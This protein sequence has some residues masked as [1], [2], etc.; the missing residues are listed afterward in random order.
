MRTLQITGDSAYG[1][2]TYLL[3]KWCRYLVEKGCSV[4]VVSTDATTISALRQIAGVRVIDNIDIPR[5]IAPGADIPSFLPA[6]HA[7]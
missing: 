3:L 5:E 4:D 2:D 1:G 7:G 6:T